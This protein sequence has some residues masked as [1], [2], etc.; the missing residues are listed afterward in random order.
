MLRVITTLEFF[1]HHF[2][3][4][5]HRDL[6]VT[7]NLSQAIKQP[8]LPT[9]REASAAGRLRPNAVIVHV[10]LSQKHFSGNATCQA[11]NYKVS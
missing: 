6:L 10:D 2:S 9:S 3:E 1:Q 5:G 7:H 8:P 11:L 4:M